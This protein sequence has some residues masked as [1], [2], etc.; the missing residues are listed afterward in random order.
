MAQPTQ[1]VLYVVRRVV[2]FDK[3]Y[4]RGTN[5]GARHLLKPEIYTVA[6]TDIAT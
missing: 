3:R 5:L 1:S 4:L 6:L 2:F